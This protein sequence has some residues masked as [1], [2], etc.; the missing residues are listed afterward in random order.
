M[1]GEGRGQELPPELQKARPK[2][3]RLRVFALAAKVISHARGL[4][5]RVAQRLLD[6]VDA[7]A[8][9]RRTLA[10]VPL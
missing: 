5:A 7:L 1:R 4:V 9:R 8:V 10:L 2:R 6:A 3:L